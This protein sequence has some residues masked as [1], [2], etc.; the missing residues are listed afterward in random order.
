MDRF[1]IGGRCEVLVGR[2]LPSPLLEPSGR[3]RRAPVLTQPGAEPIA[4]R[5]A[6]LLV[7]EGLDSEVHIFPDGDEAKTLS[8]VEAAYR[9][10]ASLE[11]G[12]A[13]TLVAVG[14]G[15]VTDAAGFVAATWMRGIEIVH[16]PTTLLGAVDASIGGKTGVNISGKNLVGVFWHP[17]RVLVDLDILEALPSDL[18]RE[19]AAEIIKAGL[20]ADLGIIGAYLASGVDVDLAD[21][22]GR[23]V[24]VK[25]RIV[26][27][28]FTEQGRRGLLNLGHTI[29]HAVEFA[30]EI[31]HGRA[32]AVGMVAAAAVSERRLGFADAG[33]VTEVLKRTGLPTM[34]PS[35]NRDEVR[36]LIALD[37]K[38]TADTVRMV[39]LEEVERPRLVDVDEDDLSHALDAIGL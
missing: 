5:V 32:V 35:A 2:G 28:D 19:G 27:E 31:T 26:D 37:K 24:G 3:R 13:D 30:T 15:A 9:W 23:A 22:V 38:R 36:S 25:A 18:K 29:G 33:L 16:I 11:A 4:R 34:S 20:L 8:S 6:G 14:G 1:L 12:R 21:V 17:R 10:L 39:L 7:A